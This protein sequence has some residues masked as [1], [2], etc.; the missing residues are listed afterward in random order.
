VESASLMLVQLPTLASERPYG[1]QMMYN[2][3][4]IRADTKAEVLEA[5]SKLPHEPKQAV[6][7]TQAHGL[8][9]S[10]PAAD[11]RTTI[12]YDL[13]NPKY[14]IM[15]IRTYDDEH[16]YVGREIDPSKWTETMEKL[17]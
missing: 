2:Y 4:F 15:F 17:S 6:S 10:G 1:P 14:S 3:A 16:E 7:G 5:V 9:F 12:W 13:A 11:E 8:S